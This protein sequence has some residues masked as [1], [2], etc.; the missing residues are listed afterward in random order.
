MNTNQP[1]TK[2]TNAPGYQEWEG[3]DVDGNSVNLLDG[4]HKLFQTKIQIILL[5]FWRTEPA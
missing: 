2:N 1:L 5:I 3:E 4:W